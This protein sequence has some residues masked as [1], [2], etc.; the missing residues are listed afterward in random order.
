MKVI[1]IAA[2]ADNGVIGSGQDM[3]WHIREDFRRFKKV[4]MGHTLVFGRRTFEQI[5]TLP[6]RRHI[7]CTRDPHWSSEGVVVAASPREAVEIARGAGEEICFIAGGGQIYAD[8]LDLC[9]ELDITEVHQSPEGSV[10]FPR[11]DR[12]V[13]VETRREVHDGF[14][15]VGYRRR[16]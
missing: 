2:V 1:A 10:T 8:A 4:T 3:L 16:A 14:D 6:G 15:F 9:D 7:I 11:I 12:Q 5:G 13:W